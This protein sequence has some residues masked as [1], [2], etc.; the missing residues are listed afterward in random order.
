MLRALIAIVVLAAAAWF[1]WWFWASGQHERA[2]RAWFEQ[3][4]AAGWSAEYDDISVSG[5]P[6]RIDTTVEGLALAD[7]A[8]GW[9]WEAPFF[10]TFQLVYDPRR[11]IAYW[12]E[13]QTVAIPGA[14]AT[15]RSELM[16]ASAAFADAALTVERHSMEIEQI[17]MASDS[18][19]TAS[20][21]SYQH[22]LRRL[23]TPENAYAFR[24]EAERLRPPQFATRIVDPTGALPS[25]LSTVMADGRVAFDRPLDRYAFEGEKPRVRALSLRES[26]I[27]WGDLALSVTGSAE[28]DAEGYAEGA[29]DISARNWR[30][31][32]AMAVESGAIGES[33]RDTLEEA[34]GFLAGIGGDPEALEATLTLSGGFAR[35]GPIPIGPAPRLL[36]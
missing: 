18:G 32:L 33:F 11:V 24:I 23:A 28:A 13:E 8:E 30:R 5:F 9:A 16:R 25:Y 26:D 15:V 12:P 29:F 1:G 19:W 10:Q 34:L 4:R 21:A 7:P 14:R 35:L 3:R 22:H 27:R 20:A 31:M 6:N 17:G 36:R 2:V